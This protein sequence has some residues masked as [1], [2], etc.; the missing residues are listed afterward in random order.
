[1]ND[2]YN[3]KL[4]KKLTENHYV[5]T[6]LFTIATICLIL[7][8]LEYKKKTRIDENEIVGYITSKTRVIQRKSDSTVVWNDVEQKTPVTRR[9]TIRSEELSNAV[10][11]LNDGTEL[12]VDENSMVI[13]DFSDKDITINLVQGN[14]RAE[15]KKTD[16]VTTL[17]ILSEG[18]KITLLDGDLSLQK[19]EGEDIKL[20]SN[21]GNAELTTANGKKYSVVEN[22]VLSKPKGSEEYKTKTIELVLNSPEDQAYLQTEDTNQVNFSWAGGE[23]KLEVSRDPNF[24]NKIFTKKGNGGLSTNLGV[25]SFFWRVNNSKSSS[26]VRKF[27]VVKSDPILL[28]SPKENSSFEENSLISFSWTIPNQ[29]SDSILEISKDSS[30]SNLIKSTPTKYNEVSE[31]FSEQGSYFFRVRVQFS[32]RD[33]KEKFTGVRKFIIKK[34]DKISKLELEAPINGKI[35]SNSDE[36]FFIWKNGKDAISYQFEISRD[37]NFSDIVQNK[38]TP[39]NFTESTLPNGNYFWRV[40]LITK[41]KDIIISETKNF[42]V[43]DVKT[44]SLSLLSPVSAAKVISDFNLNWDYSGGSPAFLVQI[45]N[46]LDFSN[47]VSKDI[48]RNKSISKTL[49]EGSYF[50]RV[51]VLGSDGKE[52]LV[53][54]PENFIVEKEKKETEEKKKEEIPQYTGPEPIFPSNG[55]SIKSSS[56]KMSFSWVKKDQESFYRIYIFQSGELIKKL[57]TSRSE[58]EFDI[59]KYKERTEFS[60]KLESWYRDYKTGQDEKAESRLIQFRV[61]PSLAPPKVLDTKDVYYIDEK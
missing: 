54:K 60:W 47:I 28:T 7:L 59:S 32:N 55:D 38:T 21:R 53:S 42:S 57:D 19:K 26:V 41:N 6:F 20:I 11:T 16:P 31:S 29:E 8:F 46:E 4:R 3:I 39:K 10:I 18:T 37:Q 34:S 36:I 13:L 17:N 56:G 12:R 5:L 52:G 58:I 14:I 49:K 9:D 51:V 30:F 2:S 33:F 43:S 44:A 40:K 24:S 15:R 25:G 45:S 1:M 22:Q 27:V 48:S 50:W 35:F 61:V 23:A